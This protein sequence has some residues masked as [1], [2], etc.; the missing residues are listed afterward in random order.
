MKILKIIDN[1]FNCSGIKLWGKC[2]FEPLKNKLIPCRAINRIPKNPNTVLCCLFPYAVKDRK[3]NISKY[4][5]F[6]DYHIIVSNFLNTATAKLIK[7][8]PDFKFSPFCDN[9]P[10]PEVYA[11][12]LCGLGCIGK[13]GLL[14]NENYGSFV[15][16]G[17]IVT[18]MPLSHKNASI[19]SCLSC[20]RCINFCPGKAL[21]NICFNKN[22]C[23]SFLSQ[24]KGDLTQVEEQIVAGT[25]LVWGCDMCQDVCPMNKNIKTTYIEEFKQNIYPLINSKNYNTLE[26][27]AFSWRPLEVIKRNI[28][29][30]EKGDSH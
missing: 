2:S 30:Q 20:N 13:N 23:A 15:F 18:D 24:K 19:T 1:I 4:A 10:I 17:E 6:N 27:R 9:S 16:I 3:H 8:F 28:C 5:F 11:A 12:A 29:I 14:I 25:G 21:S 7:A 22:S 26:H